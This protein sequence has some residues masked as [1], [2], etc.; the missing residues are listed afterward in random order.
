M[1]KMLK[2]RLW[3]AIELTILSSSL[4]PAILVHALFDFETKIVAMRG[5]DLW[6]AEGVCGFLMV[7]LASWFAVLI[8][9]KTN[10]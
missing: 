4:I 7:V 1:G 8:F 5:L 3:L 9:R 10:Y 2:D 6:L